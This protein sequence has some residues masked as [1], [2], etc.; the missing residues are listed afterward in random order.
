VKRRLVIGA[1]AVLVAGLAVVG[2]TVRVNVGNGDYGQASTIITSAVKANGEVSA[3][4]A[5]LR[6]LPGV[7]KVAQVFS[8]L[9]L[10]DPAATLTVAMKSSSS[11]NELIAVA[12]SVSNAWARDHMKS[13]LL[14]LNVKA[15]SL[16]VRESRFGP[17][18]TLAQQLAV[19]T[20]LLSHTDV[21]IVG[22]ITDAPSDSSQA[23][24]I[25]TASG[26]SEAARSLAQSYGSAFSSSVGMAA[27]PSWKLPGMNGTGALP[28]TPVLA[29]FSASAQR[30]PVA[31][32]NGQHFTSGIS[33]H[34]DG[35]SKPYVHFYLAYLSSAGHIAPTAAH[36]SE[37][38]SLAKTVIASGITGL[39]FAYEAFDRGMVVQYDFYTGTCDGRATTTYEKTD[40]L[41][42]LGLT[43]SQL[44]G[45]QPGQC[46][47]P[48]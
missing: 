38:A 16:S 10:P 31:E 46:L 40:D 14:T 8:P 5:R 27:G 29:L 34:L 7:A 48:A 11:S 12:G 9:H 20:A 45:G 18:S 43:V 32:Q 23:L 44:N 3:E 28:P 15:G 33:L 25:T 37:A 36:A 26:S 39:N 24:T 42:V 4:A 41:S 2:V 13:D 21:G 47:P 1:A 17:T 19:W 30:L 35:G 6:K 22:R